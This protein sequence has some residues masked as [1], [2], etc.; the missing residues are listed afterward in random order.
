[1][2]ATRAIA[3]PNLLSSPTLCSLLGSSNRNEVFNNGLG[4][5]FHHRQIHNSPTSL[6]SSTTDANNVPQLTRSFCSGSAS[7]QPED[8][9]QQT[10]RPLSPHLSVYQPQLNST[11]S[12]TNRIS[13]AFL[14]TMVVYYYLHVKMGSICYSYPS[15]Y[16]FSFY[17]AK[18]SKVLL[19]ISALAIVYHAWYG[20]R[21]LLDEL[22]AV[23]FR[24]GLR[25]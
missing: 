25:K 7:P 15:F 18:F 23:I 8:K 14:A 19:E 21:H 16:Q 4:S 3:S 17:S 24:R 5:F 13:G 1:M 11:L 6:K 22:P 2:R 9:K 20:V 12:I 10:L